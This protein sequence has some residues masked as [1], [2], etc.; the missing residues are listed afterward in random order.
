MCWRGLD[1][2]ARALLLAALS[3]QAQAAFH[4][5]VLIVGLS[6]NG[7]HYGDAFILTDDAGEYYVDETWLQRWEVSRPYPAGRDYEGMR[8]YPVSGFEGATARLN[9]QQMTLDVTMPPRLLPLRVIDMRGEEVPRPTA[10]L[11]AYMDYDWSYQDQSGA[12]TSTFSTLLRPVAFNEH[13]NLLANLLYQDTSGKH[14]GRRRDGLKVLDL[15]FTRDD[16]E[17]IRSLRIGDI[18][19][20]SG[21]LGRS[22]RLGGVQFATNFA[23]R[24]TLITYPLPSFYG[25]TAV[26]T[27]LD[28]YVNGRLTQRET[29]APGNF[30]LDDIP[31]VNG[32]GQM[33][34]VTEDALGRQ[35]VFIQDFYISTDLLA[36]GLSD[37]SFNLGAMREAYGIENFEYGDIA[38]SATWRYGWRDDLTVEGH[39]EFTDGLAAVTGSARYAP[40]R[41]IVSGGLGLSSGGGGA[42]GTWLVG[43]QL[44][45]KVFSYNLR[46]SGT[47][48]DFSLVG[49]NEPLPALQVFAGG[50]INAPIRGSLGAALTHQQFRDRA[51]RSI[52]SLHYST[53]FENRLSLTAV[54]SYVS[55]EEDDLTLG[56]RFSLP[57]GEQ[58]FASGGISTNR[59][60]TRV[61]VEARRN[62]PA[63]PGYGYNVSLNTGDNTYVDAGAVAQ[64]DYGTALLALRTSDRGSDWNIGSSGS[65]ATLGGMTRATRQIR[66][67]FAVVDVGGYEGVRVYAENR[68]VGRTDE[69]GRLFI[70]GLRPYQR[71]QISIEVD[72][73]PLTARI[74]GIRTE[75]SPYLRSGVVVE[76]EIAEARDAII[77]VV[78]PDGTPVRQGAVGRVWGQQAWSPV[79]S[80][81]RLYLHGLEQP[82]QVTIR[83]NGSVCDFIVPEP[84]D[85]HMI[86]DLGEFTCEPREFE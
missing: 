80:N 72:D 75:T 57:F 46:V 79:G 47:T 9:T 7:Q 20:A 48:R 49:I 24:P 2:I 56:L 8:Y 61:Q 73:L 31:V 22:L 50:G 36:E 76:F 14:T 66:E 23:T 78:L 59:D 21:A 27:A 37:Y 69:N 52:L 82:S 51:D 42:G 64:N 1:R 81:G 43:Y 68:E 6:F 38:G 17:S 70:P 41:G 34:I 29:V 45:D 15:T 44:A 4:E 63:G 54:A 65:V 39:F 10:S 40:G 16:P 28:V 11:G 85:S 26:P 32:A 58:H 53:S 84:E 60:T 13:G 5:D 67:A 71:N 62:L 83:W 19:T 33:Q 18:I 25:Q 74:D 86:P 77:R 12:G 35:Q 3:L 30:I 55:A